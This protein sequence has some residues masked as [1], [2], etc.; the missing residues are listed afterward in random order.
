MGWI[1]FPV[2]SKANWSC[3]C[4]KHMHRVKEKKKEATSCSLCS[5]DRTPLQWSVPLWHTETFPENGRCPQAHIKRL[6]IAVGR[7]S[8]LLLFCLLP[9]D[10]NPEKETQLSVTWQEDPR[11]AR[12]VTQDRTLHNGL[13]YDMWCAARRFTLSLLFIAQRARSGVELIYVPQSAVTVD[14]GW[15][16]GV[17]EVAE[18]PALLW[19][20]W[21]SAVV[22]LI[23][24]VVYFFYSHL[25]S[26]EAPGCNIHCNHRCISISCVCDAEGVDTV[27]QACSAAACL[28]L[29]SHNNNVRKW[30]ISHIL[31]YRV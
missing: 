29:D 17:A 9:G 20:D 7:S 18:L 8:L 11:S 3:S 31:K 6:C 1:T 25:L 21:V 4:V 10:V 5:L 30:N 22:M 16:G 26:A 12:V 2:L 24:I 14:G 19:S 13:H 27:R 28:G 23:C 15:C